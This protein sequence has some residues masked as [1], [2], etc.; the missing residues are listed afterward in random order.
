MRNRYEKDW[1]DYWNYGDSKQKSGKPWI[2]AAIIIVAISAYSIREYGLANSF[3]T[4]SPF[5]AG[6][7]H[8]AV[9]EVKVIS[10]TPGVLDHTTGVYFVAERKVETKI[11]DLLQTNLE[12]AMNQDIDVIKLQIQLDEIQNELIELDKTPV[13]LEYDDMKQ[14]NISC[15]RAV[16]SLI[17]NYLS[18]NQLN[19]ES[20][21]NVTSDYAKNRSQNFEDKK[22]LFDKNHI[23]YTETEEDGRKEIH[24]RYESR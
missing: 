1:R 11:S 2:F 17:Q 3:D 4:K 9:P 10:R 16:L 19:Y 20:L 6:N 21:I 7:N 15:F 24:Y 12:A 23:V 18:N 13:S 8:D 22:L 5:S 14:S